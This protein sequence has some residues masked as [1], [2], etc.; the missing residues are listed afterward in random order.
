MMMDRQEIRGRI[1][2]VFAR[3][4]VLEACRR[5]DRGTG[6]PTSDLSMILNVLRAHGVTQGVIAGLTGIPQS[7]LSEYKNGLRQPTL[8][9]LKKFAD[10]LELPE[11]ARAALGLAPNSDASE[12]DGAADPEGSA[13]LLTLAWLAGSLN[14]HADR[15][16][17]LRL[18]ATL[19]AAPLL[20]VE[21]SMERLT[22]ALLGPTV[23]LD[24]TVTFLEQRTNGLHRIEP[25]FPARLVHR[26]IISHLREVTALLEGHAGDPLWARLACTAGE[27][28]VLAA[29]TAWDLGE[30][31]HS[32]RMYRITEAAA[33]A[34][35]DPVIMACAYTY[36]S[37]GTSGP[38]AHEDA[39][40]MLLEARQCLPATGENA[41]QAWVLGREAEEAAAIG[42]P[43]ARDII[44]QAAEAFDRAQ[45]RRERP[46]T[47][48]L[49]ET[50]MNALELAT[51]TRL[52]DESKVH[53]LAD[54]LLATVTP[55][56]KRAALVNA[57]VG[58][59][60]VRLGDVV[61][62]ISYGR[63][64]LEAVRASETS[65]G[66]WRLVDLAKALSQDSRAREFC[67]EVRQVR[68]SL[69]SPH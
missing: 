13:D 67:A 9:T 66:M 36:R 2:R 56:S 45:P 59:A 30:A 49:D 43:A 55:A 48:F 50:R 44:K 35:G 16:A 12:K 37:Y 29:W 3:E 58:I 10:G 15:R 68:R 27:C 18:G 4:D 20:G 63:R 19:A 53:Q 1:E 7:R 25:M 54:N 57:D 61:S 51:Y 65:F 33:R 32:A 21:E 47:G 28:A 23:L 5:R 31:A 11:P 64:S 24:D 26:A 34:A 6:S 40:K 14:N 62:G 52:G 46:W 22:C 39:R 69:A 8:D 41:T 60:S 42:D 17:I 38:T